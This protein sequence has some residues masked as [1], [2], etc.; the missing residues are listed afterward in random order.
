VL[1]A[2]QSLGRNW[3]GV[4]VNAQFRQM[5]FRR[6]AH[7]TPRAQAPSSGKSLAA[8]N[9]K[10]R[11]LKYAIQLYK[12]VAPT[13][14]LTTADVPLVVVQA[15]KLHRKPSPH[16][17][18]GCRVFLL[19]S[20]ALTAGKLSKLKAGIV[21]ALSKPPLSK[22]QL[23]VEVRV[24]RR[25]ALAREIKRFEKRPIYRYTQGHFWRSTPAKISALVKKRK[26][27]LPDIVSDLQV[28]ERPAY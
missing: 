14:R 17:V 26:V 19:A 2:A 9:L 18:T 4:D 27:N 7:E 16:W 23:E 6:L 1:V 15:G 20:D 28:N 10:L 24:V 25:A 11:Q 22:Y 12:R 3:V 21:D 8:T 5:F 13:L